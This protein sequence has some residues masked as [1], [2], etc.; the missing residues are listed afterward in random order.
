[1]ESY[2]N[3]IQSDSAIERFRNTPKKDFKQITTKNEIEQGVSVYTT[4][5]VGIVVDLLVWMRE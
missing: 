2:L 3:A 1:M 4:S 5:S